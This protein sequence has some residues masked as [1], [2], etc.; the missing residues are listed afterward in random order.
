MMQISAPIDIEDALRADVG[1][2]C[3]LRCFAPPAPDSLAPGSVC[4]TSVGGTAQTEVS[5]EYSVS[6]D[7]WA[8]DYAQAMADANEV[9]GIVAALPF[10]ELPSGRCYVTA[11]INATPY[12]NPDPLRPTLPRATFR[13]EVGIRGASIF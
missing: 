10:M 6:V 8:K 1:G 11:E 9:A 12:I 2:L 5:H 4:F 13:A 7:C 3:E